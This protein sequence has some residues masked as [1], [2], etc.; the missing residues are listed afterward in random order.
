MMTNTL[1]SICIPVYNGE[2]YLKE[3][4]N[5][6]ISQTYS[7]IE[8]IIVEDKSTD[9]TLHIIQQFAAKDSRIKIFINEIN[10]G[11][12]GNWNHCIELANGEWVKFLFQ[13]DYIAINMIEKMMGHA[14]PK[15]KFIVCNREFIFDD[16]V[17][18]ETR[19]LYSYSINIDLSKIFKLTESTFLSPKII[20]QMLPI[21]RWS[22]FIGEPTV[23]FFH[24]SITNKIGYFNQ[25][26]A[27]ICDL[28]YW[29]RI[30]TNY[31]MLY[32]PESLARFRVHNQSTSTVNRKSK[33]ELVDSI[34]ILYEFCYG[35]Y[36]KIFRNNVSQYQKLKLKLL[37]K[38]Q[39]H[40]LQLYLKN[41]TDQNAKEYYLNIMEQNK[42]IKKISR[43]IGLYYY[44]IPLILLRRFVSKMF[45]ITIG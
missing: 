36:F 32:M 34:I 33:R 1:V 45:K 23:A 40:R 37:L 6:A 14:S 28:E 19:N 27:Q 2:K 25:A 15:N 3:C 41:N 30:S 7:N 20:S 11:L 12:V 17:S 18:K 24:K 4:L 22:N 8:I 21:W 29:L 5:S 44:L 31:G 42:E 26:L 43:T 9:N 35:K 13:D 16:E 38:R 10:L 39:I